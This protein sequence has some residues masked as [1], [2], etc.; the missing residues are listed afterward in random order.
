MHSR[1][2]HTFKC[3]VCIIKFHLFKFGSRSRCSQSVLV[4]GRPLISQDNFTCRSWRRK[5]TLTHLNVWVLLWSSLHRSEKLRQHK[6]P[7]VI[8]LFW[9]SGCCNLW[10]VFNCLTFIL[11]AIWKTEDIIKKPHQSLLYCR[12]NY[13]QK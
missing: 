9:T 10:Q 3:K 4:Y 1:N 12:N 13:E 11:C 8:T 7:T 2:T 5:F 6:Q